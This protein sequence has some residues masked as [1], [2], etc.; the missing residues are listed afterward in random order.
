MN[1]N[2]KL[3]A[4]LGYPVVHS[5]SPVLFERLSG[6]LDLNAAYLAFD[7]RP[8]TLEKSID[9]LVALG[10]QGANITAP[11]KNSMYQMLGTKSMVATEVADAM[12]SV[13]VLYRDGDKI[14]GTCTDGV[15]FLNAL[16]NWADL[17]KMPRCAILGNGAMAKVAM[18]G[19][20]SRFAKVDLYCRDT[21]KA[22][23]VAKEMYVDY[24]GKLPGAMDGLAVSCDKPDVYPLSETK[25]K[26][27]DYDL[28]VNATSCGLY[29]NVDVSPVDDD[30]FR[31][32]QYVY[33]LIYSPEQTRLLKAASAA[34]CK[35]LNGYT[36]LVNQLVENVRLWYPH[37]TS[38]C[39]TEE[40]VE[41]CLKA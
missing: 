16:R 13:N 38:G 23:A 17:P 37:E 7:V 24:L 31:P 1:A 25:E 40:L 6:E 41:F 14:V 22:S 12:K 34:G 32:G 18:R 28:V 27:R 4:L 30:C 29:P 19:L 11:Y 10:F 9:G 26:L 8:N 15:A 35:T 5:R 20:W 21:E 36:M 3:I 2:T 33:D 39:S